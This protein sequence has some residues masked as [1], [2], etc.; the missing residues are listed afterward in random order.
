MAPQILFLT[1]FMGCGKSTLGRRAASL[2][3]LPF[4]DLDILV[5]KY[6]GLSVKNIFER[7][8]EPLFRK[9]ELAVLRRVLET[10]TENSGLIAMGGG[11]WIQSSVRDI[12]PAQQ[13]I[14]L[15]VSFD[16]L[17]HRLRADKHRPLARDA[18]RLERLFQDRLPHYQAA[19]HRLAL[20][21]LQTEEAS[22]ALSNLITQIL[23]Q[24][25]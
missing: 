25:A 20:D 18:A 12:L 7:H 6:A 17:A 5:E 16:T 14:F 21:G 9:C 19:G 8:G 11:T 22:L 10:P 23:R 1:G 13:V 2:L 4:S 24:S 3:Q 15:D